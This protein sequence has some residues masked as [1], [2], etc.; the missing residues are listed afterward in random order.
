MHPRQ[1]FNTLL[2]SL[3]LLFCAG[4]V[5]PLLGRQVEEATI[6]QTYG[7]RQRRAMGDPDAHLGP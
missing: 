4:G 1:R 6:Y 2:V 5:G 7:Y 3:L